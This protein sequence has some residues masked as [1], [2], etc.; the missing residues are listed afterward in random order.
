[1]AIAKRTEAVP[2]PAL[3]LGAIVSFQMGAA[4]ATHLFAHATVEGTVFLRCALG[5][6]FLVA[7]ARPKLSGRP[8]GDL[9]VLV[10]LGVVLAV[11]NSAYYQAIHRLPLAIAVTVEF[12]GPLGVAVA[13]SQRRI[14]LLW[15]AM[16]ATGVALVAGT[17]GGHAITATGLGFALVAAAAWASY[18]LVAKRV[19]ARWPGATGLTFSFAVAA[20]LLAPIGGRAGI[21]ALS[22]GSTAALALA[23][24]VFSTALPFT[25][26]LAA[27]RRMPAR[28]YGVL[29]C[30]EPVVAAIVGIIFLS[31]SLTLWEMLAAGLVVTASIGATREAPGRPEITPN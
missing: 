7:V 15:V 17:P 19:G 4:G 1:M 21:S 8:L 14:D 20:V 12:L 27:L 28:V 2:A 11:M 31:Q 5:A 18:I 9:G 16:A 3:Q 25:L 22:S 24:A 6:A 26:E 30:L 23:V 13:A 29:T 10:V